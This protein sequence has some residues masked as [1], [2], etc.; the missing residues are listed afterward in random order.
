MFLQNLRVDSFIES[1]Y[2]ETKLDTEVHLCQVII[3]IKENFQIN[4]YNVSSPNLSCFSKHDFFGKICQHYVL[5]LSP[6]PCKIL[7]T[8]NSP[9]KACK[10]SHL[11]WIT[12]PK[13]YFFQ[14]IAKIIL[15]YV[16]A[17]WILKKTGRKLLKW[18]KQAVGVYLYTL[19]SDKMVKAYRNTSVF[20]VKSLKWKFAIYMRFKDQYM[21]YKLQSF[22]IS[23]W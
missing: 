10:V 16:F 1:Q 15:A 8:K 12:C 3:I 21:L 9:I 20:S 2:V 13:W 22:S 4:T 6:W 14:K 5:S 18:I 7:G 19:N 17:P 11:Y 23:T